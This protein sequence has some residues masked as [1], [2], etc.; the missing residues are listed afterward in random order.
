MVRPS[1]LAAMVLA[2]GLWALPTPSQATPD[3]AKA[4]S[5]VKTLADRAT[6]V[7]SDKT[8]PKSVKDSKLRAI[9]RDGFDVASIGK[10]AL[11]VYRRRASPAQIKAYLPAFESFIVY[12]Y[13]RR[14]GKYAGETVKV[15]GNRAAGRSKTDIFV[16]TEVV[17]KNR[18][19][20]A[21]D[22]RIRERK[23]VYRVIDIEIAGTSQALTYKQEF[24]S[25]IQRHGKG[26]EGLI[27]ELRAKNAKPKAET[28]SDR[29]A[30]E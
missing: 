3:P 5:F 2:L 9:L 20:L 23:G 28:E 1:M 14:F 29:A 21:I 11:G 25:V 4:E 22:W 8:L 6:S 18:E 7:V 15:I 27:D 26:V 16:R 17:R 30:A 10:F 13:T 12:T 24:A 19:P